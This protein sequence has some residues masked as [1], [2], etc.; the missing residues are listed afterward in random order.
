LAFVFV[1]LEPGLSA[2][3]AAR[4][5]DPAWRPLALAFE[6]AVLEEV[7]FRLFL[8]SLIVWLLGRGWRRTGTAPRAAVVWTAVTISA[9]LFGLAHVPAWLSAT[10]ATPLLV[11]TVLLLNGIAGAVLGQVY[12]RWGIEAAI[13]CHGAADL[14]VQS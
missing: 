7:V 14:V 5:R 8:L 13:A 3:F 10:A 1:P 2:R 4:A 12:W 6:S 11:A 9:L